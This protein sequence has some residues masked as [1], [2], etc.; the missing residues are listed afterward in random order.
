MLTFVFSLTCEANLSWSCWEPDSL[1]LPGLS[2]SSGF[3]SALM[4]CVVSLACC[5]VPLILLLSLLGHL[6]VASL[7]RSFGFIVRV[8]LVLLPPRQRVSFVLVSLKKSLVSRT[9][10]QSQRTA[11]QRKPGDDVNFVV[12]LRFKL[13]T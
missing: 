5:L 4:L 8:E 3:A 13:K 7:P 11:F 9:L 6:F 12:E 2:V 10:S 1:P